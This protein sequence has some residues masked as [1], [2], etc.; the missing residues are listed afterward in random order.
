MPEGI[1]EFFVQV[2]GETTTVVYG[3]KTEE[4]K[5]EKEWQPQDGEIVFAETKARN[6]HFI[7][8]YCHMV[9]VV[10]HDLK[11]KWT[12]EFGNGGFIYTFFRP[13]TEEEKKM[14]H[15]AMK[16]KGLRWNAEEKKV[17]KLPRWRAEVGDY[18]Y[19]ISYGLS[20]GRCKELCEDGDEECYK[21]GN[22]FKTKEAAERVAN[23]IREIYKNSKAE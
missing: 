13:A 6:Q 8:P 17:E 14:F 22:Y 15:D 5:K 12:L 23:Q 10:F 19:Y 20:I 4:N 2:K 9:D 21:C 3:T 18:Y 16:E 7:F 1:T 11:W